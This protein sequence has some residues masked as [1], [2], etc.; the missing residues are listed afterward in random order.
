MTHAYEL[1]MYE[2]AVPSSM[3]WLEKLSTAKNA[4]YDFV[5]ISIDETDE[6]LARLDMSLSERIEFIKTMEA[7]GIFV[8][9]MCLSGHRKYP[10]GSGD[11]ATEKRSLEIMQKAIQFAADV[12]IRI[13]MLAG[14][15][16]YYEESTAQT[17]ARFE[18]NV[19]AS[20]EMAA[21]AGV[22]LAFET[23]ETPFMDTVAKARQHVD[24]VHSPYLQI[25]PDLGNITNAAHIYGTSAVDDLESGRGALA[26]VHIKETVP[27]KY[28]EIPF[29]TGHVDFKTLLAKSW[30]L[31]VRRYVTELWYANNDDWQ[32]RLVEAVQ[33]ARG[34]LDMNKSH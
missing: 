23:M 30:S 26:G 29:G 12:G 33:L 4:G 1:G 18:R 28:R 17:T 21:S 5:E 34:I 7:A 16:V 9:S 24:A 15:D 32:E 19:R 11:A 3:T 10:L 13:I 20:V 6:K 14:Y 8:R 25:Y 27:G 2:K 31:G 22:L